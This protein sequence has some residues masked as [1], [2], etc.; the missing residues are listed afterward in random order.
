MDSLDN[1]FLGEEEAKEEKNIK[2]EGKMKEKNQKI[3][4]IESL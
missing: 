2:K 4:E 3:E 1:I